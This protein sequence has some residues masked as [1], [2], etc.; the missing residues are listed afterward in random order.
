[1]SN[2]Y[3]EK[4]KYERKSSG[5]LFRV[6]TS[7]TNCAYTVNLKDI[8]KGGTFIRTKHRPKVDE[9]ITFIV[10]DD[11]NKD[12]FV[13]NARVA[14]CKENGPEADRGFGIQFEKEFAEEIVR[15]LHEK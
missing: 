1:M 3:T 12:R 11:D 14:W 5:G 13:G 10:L 4:R 7:V 9:T 6:Y 8:S 2:Q 15:E